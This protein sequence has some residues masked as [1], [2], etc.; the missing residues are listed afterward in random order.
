[1]EKILDTL[2]GKMD[3]D[4]KNQ[5]MRRYNSMAS[6]YEYLRDS[7]NEDVLLTYKYKWND[8]KYKVLFAL[9]S[10][11]Q[12]VIGPL[13]CSAYAQSAS[14]IGTTIP[15]SYGKQIQFDNNWNS[16]VSATD[17]AFSSLVSACG[18]SEYM[19]TANKAS[20]ITFHIASAIKERVVDD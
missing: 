13:A 10:F 11:Y 18:F 9:N 20:D 3:R 19:V 15:I 16:R 14:G 2:V 5:V 7:K 12:I 8:Q 6:Q 4:V 17:R 1:M